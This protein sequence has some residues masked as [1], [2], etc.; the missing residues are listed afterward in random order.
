MDFKAYFLIP[1]DTL[2]DYIAFERTS[3]MS[4]ADV[5]DGKKKK[6]TKEK[7]KDKKKEKLKNLPKVS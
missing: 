3:G 2:L 7:E 1:K 5:E 4:E 6:K